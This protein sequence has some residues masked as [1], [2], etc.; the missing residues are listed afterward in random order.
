MR[1]KDICISWECCKRH[2]D[3]IVWITVGERPKFGQGCHTEW[4]TKYKP[5]V[6]SCAG[7]CAGMSL[8]SVW[9]V[10]IDLAM[11]SHCLLFC[12]FFPLSACRTPSQTRQLYT[13]HAAVV[14]SE[15]CSAVGI[16]S[17]NTYLSF[18]AAGSGGSLWC[19]WAVP[20]TRCAQRLKVQSRLSV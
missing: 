2:L 12:C 17:Q 13:D 3:C 11:Q 20:H 15:W 7:R 5:R 4:C 9:I 16:M 18:S 14:S 8:S 6:W 10:V 1:E 19:G